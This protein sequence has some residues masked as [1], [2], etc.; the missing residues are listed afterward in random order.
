MNYILNSLE[1]IRKVYTPDIECLNTPLDWIPFTFCGIEKTIFE[2][3]RFYQCYYY[4]DDYE[5]EDLSLKD[6]NFKNK[7]HKYSGLNYDFLLKNIDL[8]TFKNEL[9]KLVTKEENHFIFKINEELGKAGGNIEFVKRLRKDVESLVLSSKYLKSILEKANKFD[10]ILINRFIVSYRNVYDSLKVEHEQD[11]VPV[12]I[13][14]SEHF[15]TIDDFEKTK[16]KDEAISRTKQPELNYI[17]SCLN[18]SP[19]I[20]SYREG[21]LSDFTSEKNE[22]KMTCNDVNEF[23]SEPIKKLTEC[24]FYKALQTKYPEEEKQQSI[25]ATIFRVHLKST[26]IKYD[27]IT[28]GG[29]TGQIDHPIPVQIDHQFRSKLTTL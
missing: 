5:K 2:S 10:E 24:G 26:H 3:M 22:K 20:K 11:I 4:G 7:S 9:E 29:K 13:F 15:K 17:D 21:I 25:I 12:I 27:I 16:N 1:E 6:F 28:V 8:E 19:L 14:K 23:L 18:P